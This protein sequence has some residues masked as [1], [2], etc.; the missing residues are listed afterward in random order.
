ME[1]S[2]LDAGADCEHNGVGFEMISNT[3]TTHECFIE[4]P[5][6]DGVQR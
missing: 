3:L 2:M 1:F 6:F 4:V 5:P